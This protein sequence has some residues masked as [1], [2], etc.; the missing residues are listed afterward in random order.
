MRPW[1]VNSKDDLY[2]CIK[3]REEKNY[4]I[5]KR[6]YLICNLRKSYIYHEKNHIYLVSH[7]AFNADGSV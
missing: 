7:I 6:F 4:R 2:K 1:Y 3:P 5:A